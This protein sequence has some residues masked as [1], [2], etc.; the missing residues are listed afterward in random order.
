MTTHTDSTP[1]L[2]RTSIAVIPVLIGVASGI[3]MTQ[4]AI[5]AESAAIPTG[6]ATL[7]YLAAGALGPRW[8]AWAGVAAGT[9]LV[10]IGEMLGATWW[11]LFAAAGVVLAA[12][13]VARR[14]R[15]T[16]LEAGGMVG[17]FG[18][19]VAALFL[20][21]ALGLGLAAAALIA[22][23]A[24]DAYHLLTDRVVPRSL[25]LWCIGLDVTAGVSCLW[26]ALTTLT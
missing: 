5:S 10:V 23:A 15:A 9:A 12:V 26:F 24:W 6:I 14:Q 17:Y 21:P 22:H 1:T 13:G 8:T 16:A 18:I 11:H 19:A 7:A 4:G 25:A 3:A 20:S 2:R